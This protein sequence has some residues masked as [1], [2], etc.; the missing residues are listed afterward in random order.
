M[1]PRHRRADGRI[2][3][4]VS[5]AL[6]RRFTGGARPARR[7]A[8]ARHRKYDDQWAPVGRRYYDVAEASG[9][10]VRIVDADESG[11]FEMIDP[12]TSTWALVRDAALELLR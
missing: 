11:H 4:S 10:D 2:A 6:P 12:A 5:R 8:T 3:G 9:D 7:V 1:R